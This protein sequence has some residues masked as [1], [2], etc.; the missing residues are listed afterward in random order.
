MNAWWVS[1]SV[2]YQVL[3]AVSDDVFKENIK[4]RNN[5]SFK[6]DSEKIVLLQVKVLTKIFVKLRTEKILCI[7]LS[8]SKYWAPKRLCNNTLKR[9]ELKVYISLKEN[10]LKF[11]QIAK[12]Q[13]HDLVHDFFK[14]VRKGAHFVT[15]VVHACPKSLSK[16]G[17]QRN[18]FTRIS[19]IYEYVWIYRFGHKVWLKKV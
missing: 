6:K 9:N 12:V 4:W 18:L 7:F 1:Q 14:K 13:V 10:K 3:N 16:Q 2:F 19:R 17:I 8:S 11:F 5:I 15:V